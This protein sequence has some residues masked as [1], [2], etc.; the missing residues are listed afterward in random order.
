MLKA[1]KILLIAPVAFVLC[2][3]STSYPVQGSKQE[4]QSEVAGH[5]VLVR[6]PAFADVDPHEGVGSKPKHFPVHGID[7]SRWQGDIDWHSARAAGVSFA[8]V[9]ATEGGDFLDPMFRTHWDGAKG[10]NVR[11]GAYHYFYFCRPAVEQARWFIE[12]V[13]RDSAALPPVLDL[14]WN[15]RS[16]TCRVRPNGID[17]RADAKV[18]LDIL[19]RHYGRRPLVYTTVDF[20]Q[21][22]ELG[23]LKNTQ[24][25]L[26]SVAGHPSE[27]YPDQAWTFWQ[28]T[29]TGIV[30]GVATPVDVNAFAGSLD[31]WTKWSK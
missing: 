5:Q 30:P 27:T 22:S 11:H 21:D 3:C 7:V 6:Y 16:P 4:V 12:N 9:K 24:F 13:P 23:Q 10:A 15:H 1:G 29:G 17:V 18:F 25:W 20:F 31:Q 8:Y 14:E 26:R 28:Y 19:E 2:S